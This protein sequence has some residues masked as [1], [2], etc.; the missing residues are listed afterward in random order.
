MV[1]EARVADDLRSVTGVAR[2]PPNVALTNVLAALPEPPDDL[3]HSRTYPGRPDRGTV[4]WHQEGDAVAFTATLPKRWGTIGTT[5]SGLFANGGWLP[6]PMV[7]DALPLL[8]WDVTV[9]LPDGTAGALGPVTGE[10]ALHWSGMGE[11]VALAV[12]RR[13]VVTPLTDTVALLT[14][15]QPRA[16][17]VRELATG[18]TEAGTMG[19]DLAG[20]VVEAPLRRRL[21]GSS[22]G[23]AY[24]SDR[25][26]R[27]T[28]GLRRYHRVAVIRGVA[29]ALIGEADP[30]ARDLAAAAVSRVHARRL[31]GSDAEGLLQRFAWIPQIQTV[32]ASQRMAFY[33]E[34]LERPHPT[35][36]VRD[37]LV[38][39]LDPHTPG[40][41]VL[42]QLDTAFGDGVGERLGL[43]LAEGLSLDD[44]SA[45]EGVPVAWIAQWR[46]PYPI[47]DY[48]LEVR[49]D[50]VS[51]RRQA[52]ADAQSE[53][54]VVH[55]DGARHEVTIPP[56]HAIHLSL[57]DVRRVVLDPDHHIGQTSRFRDT[58]PPRYTLTLAAGI[59][60]INLGRGQI[61]ASGQ[62]TLRRQ[63]DTRNLW[64]GTAF[65]APGSL[66]G[67]RIHWLRKAGPLLDG[68]SR[69]HRLTLGGGV[70]LLDPAFANVDQV[71]PSVTGS[72]GWAWDTRVSNEF[73]LRGRRLSAVVGGGAIPGVGE[74]WGSLQCKITGLVPLH[75]RHVI[76]ASTEAAM[77]RSNV[78]WR[79]LTLAGS[80]GMRA[81]PVL[82]ACRPDG[83][84]PCA[85]TA[86]LRSISMVEY[87]MAP[88][89]QISVPMFL[90]WGNGLQLT[91]GAE[92]AVARVNDRPA[93]AVGL[94]AG[95][96]GSADL[97]G[98]VSEMLGVT[99][100]WPVWWTGLEELEHTATP[101]VYLRWTQAF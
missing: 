41:V 93:A 21:T 7:D 39:M 69:P 46:R 83:A 27:L 12:V 49:D 29:G 26:F 59:G 15:G 81:M 101:E 71:R 20:A 79:L 54:L 28:P 75:P 73:P 35:D 37:D 2:F 36:P 18:L 74:R 33:G 62:M 6:Q 60:A 5:R 58:W 50:V 34:I 30:F 67:A 16:V 19:V 63:Y 13:P 92:G 99:L 48:Q 82:P 10:G 24:V 51:V 61:D 47:Q 65:T 100:G 32:L 66:V 86:D 9:Q 90:A 72:L 3:T 53:T 55:A 52:P 91:A 57:P 38:E 85:E 17:L 56:G 64:F 80:G 22:P 43:R 8:S 25:A 68:W 87:R 96:A 77:A 40:A 78:P 89:R 70:T 23:L 44:A 97:L 98:A 45:A 94:T 88:L 95:I 4:S 14:R 76:A 84:D 11:R 31:R 42:V 1:V